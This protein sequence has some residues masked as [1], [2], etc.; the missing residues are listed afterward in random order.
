MP[1]KKGVQ[2][3]NYI[4]YLVQTN[5]TFAR[6]ML[7]QA[8]PNQCQS[9]KA[10]LR[11]CTYACVLY[12]YAILK[13][14]SF[15]FGGQ[16]CVASLQEIVTSVQQI[17]SMARMLGEMVV[18]LHQRVPQIY[19][20]CFSKIEVHGTCLWAPVLGVGIWKELVRIS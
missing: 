6:V 12:A 15:F 13:V 2:E 11:R 10:F 1:R 9:K 5:V 18:L 19:A 7:V 14:Y 16:I 4:R 3:Y 20:K 17:P 8:V